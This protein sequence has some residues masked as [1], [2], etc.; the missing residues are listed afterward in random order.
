MV[1]TVD[2][3]Q[4]SLR[5]REQIDQVCRSE[6]AAAIVRA[7]ARQRLAMAEMRANPPQ[8]IEGLGGQTMAIDPVVWAALRRLYRPQPGEDGEFWDWCKRKWPEYFHVRHR[9]TRTMVG[10]TSHIPMRTPIGRVVVGYGSVSSER[11]VRFRKAYAT[12]PVHQSAN[13]L[14]S[15]Q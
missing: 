11:N 10:P 14:Q 4:L 2:L 6:T 5:D 1:L 15:P 13:P 8:A 7:K 9:P 3:T 12:R